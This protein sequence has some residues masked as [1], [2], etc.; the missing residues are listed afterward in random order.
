MVVE[1]ER[2]SHFWIGG[3]ITSHEGNHY[4]YMMNIT[5]CCW[6]IMERGYLRIRQE[7]VKTKTSE[8]PLNLT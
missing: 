5:P 7:D 6:N 8:L 1:D 4:G 2:K 3:L